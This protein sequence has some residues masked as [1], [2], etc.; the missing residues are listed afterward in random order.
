MSHTTI[1]D[2][3]YDRLTLAQL[4]DLLEAD[5]RRAVRDDQLAALQE[6][7]PSRPVLDDPRLPKVI[8][9]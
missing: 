9:A 7:F 2:R 3:A 6:Q 1:L 5:I 4:G 8:W